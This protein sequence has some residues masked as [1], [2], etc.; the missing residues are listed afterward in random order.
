MSEEIPDCAY[1]APEDPR[2]DAIRNGWPER[3][4]TSIGK[5]LWTHDQC[6][7]ATAEYEKVKAENGRLGLQVIRMQ[8][9]LNARITLEVDLRELKNE[10]ELLKSM[11]REN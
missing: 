4:M 11:A 1:A 2:W 7:Q 5:D 9:E 10:N 6:D 3:P 8:H